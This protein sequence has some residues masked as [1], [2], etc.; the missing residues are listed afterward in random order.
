MLFRHVY[1]VAFLTVLLCAFSVESRADENQPQEPLPAASELQE[2]IRDSRSQI[3]QID[4]QAAALEEEEKALMT[5]TREAQREQFNL[6]QTLLESDDDL[7]GMMEQIEATQR[8]LHSQQ[9]ALGKRMVEHTNYTQ[10]IAR[11]TTAIERSGA[12]QREAME[13]AN[14]RVRIQL[15][16]KELESQLAGMAE[17]DVPEPEGADT[18]LSA[19]DP[20]QL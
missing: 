9:E 7:R 6:R 14:D 10:L 1:S 3:E 4:A 19:E 16:L 18:T 20:D 8:D 17:D 11:Q 5:Q 2:L 13:L 15:E 12:I